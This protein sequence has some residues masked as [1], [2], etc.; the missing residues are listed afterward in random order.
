MAGGL[1]LYAYVGGNPLI[2]VDPDGT[3]AIA[4]GA[5][6]ALSGGIGGYIASGGNLNSALNGAIAGGIIGVIN[7]F[8]SYTAGLVAGSVVSGVAGQSIGLAQTNQNVFKSDNYD[9]G[10]ILGSVL[11]GTGGAK[12]GYHMA[13]RNTFLGSKI[14]KSGTNVIQSA[15]AIYGGF[16]AGIGEIIGTNGKSLNQSTRSNK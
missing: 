4:G 3:F 5:F 15:G 1:N 6:G 12:L 7:P 10:A 9:G 8:A 11:V 14:G 2:L 13:T 16:G